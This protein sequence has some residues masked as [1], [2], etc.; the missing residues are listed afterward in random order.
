MLGFSNYEVERDPNSR[1]KVDLILHRRFSNVETESLTLHHFSVAYCALII[2]YVHFYHLIEKKLVPLFDD[3]D[4][5]KDCILYVYG[6]LSL[7]QN[8]THDCYFRLVIFPSKPTG[9]LPFL[10][11]VVSGNIEG[12]HIK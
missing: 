12:Q 9:F 10:C 6:K 8:T 7:L 11:F 5:L 2:N 4:R 3:V 1:F